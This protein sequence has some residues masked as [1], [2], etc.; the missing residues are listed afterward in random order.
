MDQILSIVEKIIPLF[1]VAIGWGLNEFSHVFRSSKENKQAIAHALSVLLD[2][3]FQAVYFEHMFS[4]LRKH[5]MP[6]EAVP[7]IRVLIEKTGIGKQGLS[8][9]YEEALKVVAK[10][11]PLVAYEYRSRASFPDFLRNLRGM[12]VENG[13]PVESMED[14]ESKLNSLV[15]PRMDELVVN[16]ASFHSRKLERDVR[17]IIGKPV[18]L[19]EGINEFISAMRGELTSQASGT[20]QSGA[21]S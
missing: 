12:A 9:E 5:G 20:P 16:L 15:I 19:P 4:V 7:V 21:P 17:R 1:A 13:M 3:R 2:I 6:E 8:E 10:H 18:E 14:L 11:A